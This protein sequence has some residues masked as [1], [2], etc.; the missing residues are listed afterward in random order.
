[1]ILDL[2]SYGNRMGKAGVVIMNYGILILS[3]WAILTLAGAATSNA[4]PRK[5]E[6]LRSFY[7]EHNLDFFGDLITDQN[8]MMADEKRL[9]K[10]ELLAD[11]A[12]T[13]ALDQLERLL[14]TARGPMQAELLIRKASLLSDRAR[15]ATYFQNNPLK[16]SRLKQPQHYLEQSI[17]TFLIVERDHNKHPKMDIVVFS[18][19]YN[20][21]ELKRHDE[22]FRHYQKLVQKFSDSPLIGDARLAMSEILFD[23]R[24]FADSLAQLREIVKSEHPRLKNFALYKMAWTYYNMSDLASGIHSLEKVIEGVNQASGIHRAR[25]ELRKEALH[26]LVAFYAESPDMAAAQAAEYFTRVAAT[27][28]TIA[29]DAAAARAK[30]LAALQEKKA[31]IPEDESDA[32]QLNEAQELLFRLTQVYR[33]QGK[34]Q[35]AMIVAEL[36]IDKLPRHPRVVALYR[37][38]AESAEKLRR[39]DLVLIELERLA[40]IIEKDLPVIKSYRDGLPEAEIESMIDYFSTQKIAD[41]KTGT[42][43]TKYQPLPEAVVWDKLESAEDYYRRNLARVAL[44]SFKDFT[45]FFHG[46]WMKTN[47]NETALHAV[48][49]YDMA[50]RALLTPWRGHQIKDILEL[51]Y[52]RAQLRYALKQWDASAS[53]YAWL[54]VRRE[55]D[56]DDILRGEIAA[57]EAWLKAA[58][59]TIK[60]G[61]IHPTH[62]RLQAAYD[63]FLAFNLMNGKLREIAAGV[64]SA[65]ARMLADY[66]DRDRALKR[67]IF[68]TRY[69]HDVKDAVAL[70]RDVLVLLEKATRWED[71]R[72]YSE[73]LLEAGHYKTLPVA[74][75]L[76]QAQQ[77]AHL[78]LLEQLEKDKDW[79][80]ASKEFAEFA[81]KHAESAFASQALMK[82]AN[83]ALQLKD[84]EL[85]VKKLEAATQANDEAVRLQAW[86]GLEPFYRKAFLWKKLA[87]LYGAVLKLKSDTKTREGA[88]KNLDA[89]IELEAGRF[90]ASAASAIAHDPDL[91]KL[92]ASQEAFE[93]TTKEFMSL[94]FVKSNNNPASNF[95]RKADMH[96]KL[97]TAID[98]VVDAAPRT[99]RS[100]AAIWATVIKAELLIEF[101]ET[102]ADAA[103]PAALKGA[104]E[105]DRKAY[106][107]TISGQANELQEKARH[108][109]NDA[110]E[111]IVKVDYPLNIENRLNNLLARFEYKFRY[112][113]S[114]FAKFWTERLRIKAKDDSKYDEHVFEMG[115]KALSYENNDDLNEQLSDL[116]AYY[117]Q[118]GQTGYAHAVASH[119]TIEA[120]GDTASEAVKLLVML[121][122]DRLPEA[123]KKAASNDHLDA[124]MRW[125]LARWFAGQASIVKKSAAAFSDKEIKWFEEAITT[126]LRPARTEAMA[127]EPGRALS[128]TR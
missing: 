79:K 125:N 29:S 82:A 41:S 104:T 127:I 128:Q 100:G 66:G 3:A 23:K 119:L 123:I 61:A 60:K 24:K 25:L 46:E 56:R 58:P 102:L 34:H 78:K 21:G 122:L 111:L 88:K 124:K 113:R 94:R 117:A 12:R 5:I 50:I 20:Y 77:F 16:S 81:A 42:P 17:K 83:A 19:A 49:A 89:I 115:L 92:I 35:N 9:A 105:I 112:E 95:K 75:D 4:D 43:A 1:M 99:L 97:S 40:K 11:D 71:L 86:L 87:G 7:R 106:I 53:D 14:K 54:A 90:N 15:T 69:F 31:V 30:R 18:I 85:S 62:A 93:R 91:D 121:E 48:A 37:L 33:D 51:R 6:K 108:F 101:A 55:Q 28:N 8:D 27:P 10:L 52:R 47:S 36:I 26:D 107:E 80:K 45:N 67:M 63:R 110:A 44:E 74:K 98:K 13:K 103:L 84:S 70:T 126:L 72:D 38:R 116:A 76:N 57:L 73:S 68:Y 22:A 59:I 114:S 32:Y 64:L 2:P 39:R 65:S 109:V 120:K 118:N 96:A